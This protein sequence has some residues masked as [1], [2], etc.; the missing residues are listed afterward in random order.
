MNLS[1]RY[2]A[3]PKWYTIEYKD[4]QWNWCING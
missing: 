2:D 1:I 3:F 4:T